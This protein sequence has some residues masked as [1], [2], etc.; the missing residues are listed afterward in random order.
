MGIV[1]RYAVL[2]GKHQVRYPDG[3]TKTYRAG[4]VFECSIDLLADHDPDNPEEP[5]PGRV[6]PPHVLYQLLG[7]RKVE[8]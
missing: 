2:Q 1:Y 5:K 4:E 3:S 6:P 8:D 7:K